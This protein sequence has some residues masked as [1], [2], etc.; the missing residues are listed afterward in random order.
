MRLKI[1]FRL[2]IVSVLFL[3]AACATM[4]YG[5]ASKPRS[6]LTLQEWRR[7]YLPT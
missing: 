2:A 1:W 5:R 3:T 6:G 7:S 4:D